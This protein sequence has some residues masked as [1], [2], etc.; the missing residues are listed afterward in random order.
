[1]YQEAAGAAFGD[2]MTGF[3][4]EKMHWH[5]ADPNTMQSGLQEVCKHLMPPTQL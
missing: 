4:I 1:L 5:S 3:F 2:K